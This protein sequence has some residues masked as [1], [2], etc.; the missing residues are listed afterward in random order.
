MLLWQ[1]VDRMWSE[2]WK[3]I[4]LERGRG[5]KGN[6]KAIAAF[7]KVHVSTFA[8]CQV[9]GGLNV[10]SNLLFLNRRS[11]SNSE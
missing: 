6:G 7:V 1:L 9:A 4:R 3:P 11:S 2:R 8:E 10:S 5:R